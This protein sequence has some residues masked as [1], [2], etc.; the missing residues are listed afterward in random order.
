[1]ADS[2]ALQAKVR[3][4]NDSWGP[5]ECK[6]GTRLDGGR[7]EIRFSISQL[8]IIFMNFLE[9][10]SGSDLVSFACTLVRYL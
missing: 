5:Q 4:E 10:F 6:D 1:M 8:W 7:L 3:D 9:L 2:G